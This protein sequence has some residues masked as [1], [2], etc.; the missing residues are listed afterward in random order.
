MM[1]FDSGDIFINPFFIKEQRIE[2]A[3]SSGSDASLLIAINTI[4]G[5]DYSLNCIYTREE[6]CQIAE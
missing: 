6:S 1:R 2:F 4:A 5:G 3:L